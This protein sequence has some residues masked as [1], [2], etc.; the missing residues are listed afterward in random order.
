MKSLPYGVLIG[1]IMLSELLVDY[2]D[3]RRRSG[4]RWQKCA[5]AHNRDAYRLEKLVTHSVG[6][7]HSRLLSGRE[8]I[9]FGRDAVGVLVRPERDIQCPCSRLYARS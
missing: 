7:H 9:S 5:P 6:E 1:P 4:I 8:L 2:R 3:P